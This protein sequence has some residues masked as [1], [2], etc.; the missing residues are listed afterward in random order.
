NLAHLSQDGAAFTKA[1]AQMKALLEVAEQ[2]GAGRARWVRKARHELAH[3]L[4]RAGRHEEALPLL[5]ANAAT[6]GHFG[7]W[8]WLN[9]AAALWWLTHERERTLLLLREARAHDDRDLV[10]LFLE[11][12]EF[13]GVHDDT[14]FMEAVCRK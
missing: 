9:H 2:K 10:P 7:G 11:R 6:G 13:A 12:P 4:A 5:E 3:Q 14:E 8:G 1:A